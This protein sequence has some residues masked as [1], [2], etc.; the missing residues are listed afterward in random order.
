M[1]PE[2]DQRIYTI[3]E[4]VLRCEPPRRSVLL[5]E[6]CG[7]DPTLRS[8]VERLLA[9]D[10]R[11]SQ[12]RFLTAPNLPDAGPPGL[13]QLRGLEGHLHCPHCRNPIGLATLPA[14]GEIRCPICGST[15]RLESGSTASWGGAVRGKKL[16]RFELLAKVGSGAFGTVYK[17]R[18]PQLDRIVAVKVPRAGSLPDGQELD[19]FLREARSTAQLRHPA[20][21]PVHEVGQDE[22]V[23]YLVSDF[24]EGVT[25]SDRLTAGGVPFR[26]AATLVALVAEALDHAHRHGVVHRDVKPSNIMLRNDG[27]PLVMDFGLAK[28]AAGEITMTMDGQVLGTPAYMSPEQARGEGHTVDG[29]SDVYSLGVILYHL[30]AGE[31]PFRGNSR[32][33]L[34]QVLH[35]EPAPPRSLNDRIPRD[36]ETI[37]LKA[38]AKEPH[39]RY[40][41]SSELAADLR[42]WLA[43]EPI[44]ARPVGSFERAWRWCRREPVVA[45]LTFALLVGL[46]GVATQWRRAEWNMLRQV[47]ANRRSQERFDTAMTAIKRIEDI[48]KDAA[49]LRES[50]LEGL[51]ASLLQTALGFYRT[52]QESLEEDAS[53][54]TRFGL[55]EAYLRIGRL[56]W[57]LGRPE[58]ALTA[59]RRS[60]SMLEQMAA[61]APSD[62]VIRASLGRIHAQIG[63]YFR[64]M[65]R[66][67]EALLSYEKARATQESLA[68]DQ[69]ANVRH[70]EVL[71][72]TLSNL[73]V[74]RLELGDPD[75]AIHLHRRAIAIHEE[76]VRQVA[77]N[78]QYRSDLAWAWRY[79]GLAL[80]ASGDRDAALEQF[81]RATAIYEEFIRDDRDNVEFRWRLARCLDEVGRIHSLSGPPADAAVPLARAAEF[82]ETLVRDDPV[83]YGVDLTR[84]QLYLASQRALAGLPDEAKACL[85]RAEEIA[86]RS[87]R[88]R[89]ADLFYDMACD[90]SLWSVAG[91]DGVIAPAERE[92]RSRRAIASLRRLVEGGHLHFGQIRRDPILDPLRSRRDFQELVSD[93]SFPVGPFR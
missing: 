50:R 52:L 60:Q 73:G 10:Q 18:D 74:I 23:P 24:V 62:P 46:V 51:R 29:R 90:S 81:K 69:T 5:D 79:L 39:R 63:F 89:P 17:A 47:E 75:D 42:R 19:R 84:N 7:G 49:V 54:E 53:R 8:E 67:R 55:S 71:S 9:D 76:L 43:G 70:R 86:N 93:L 65:G 28:R 80:A 36:L 88:V 58:E 40:A 26:E 11:A 22:G 78:A 77:G 72:W 13:A 16:G 61:A 14:S 33:L 25:L 34:H 37:C 48:T 91:Q 64:T 32:M 83:L 66:P 45:S 44:T 82:Y 1:N 35:D 15:F 92:D 56:T 4:A 12:D 68:R 20:I 6:L 87:S 31:L 38:L 3:F 41:T 30:L 2:R 85:R 27:A 57:E 59:Y 21:V